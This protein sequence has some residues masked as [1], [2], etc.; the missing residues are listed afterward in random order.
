MSIYYVQGPTYS[1]INN[2]FNL[3]ISII[4]LQKRKQLINS[5]AEI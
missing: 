2:A 5:G 1:G 3:H 4:L